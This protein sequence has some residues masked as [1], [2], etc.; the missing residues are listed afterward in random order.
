MTSSI[1]IRKQNL[2]DH[3]PKDEEEKQAEEFANDHLLSPVK[4]SNSN[5]STPTTRT[6][7]NSSNKSLSQ[8]KIVKHKNNLRITPTIASS[9]DEKK[10]RPKSA[11][12]KNN[13]NRH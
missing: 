6:V 3:Y 13:N 10:Q 1:Q 4:S 7:G 5:T 2:D 11:Y 9:K 8:E 12:G